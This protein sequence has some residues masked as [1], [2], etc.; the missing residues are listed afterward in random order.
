MIASTFI[1]AL[2]CPK[3]GQFRYIGK[4]NF[5][6]K[7]IRSHI[8]ACSYSS[9]KKN[10]WIKRLRNENMV[11][12]LEILEEVDMERWQFW[13]M[14][15]ISLFKSW[16]F[17]LLNMTDGGE[18]PP[19]N[20]WNLGKKMSEGS[21]RKM[22]LA[23]MG[24]KKRAGNKMP[25]SQKKLLSK[26]NSGNKYSVGRVLS[27]ITKQKI[28]ASNKG[29]HTNIGRVYY[30]KTRQKMSDKRKGIK[31]SYAVRK[32]MSESK[33]GI[34]M[35]DETKIKIGNSNRGKRWLHSDAT[36]AKMKGHK[37]GIG[38]VVSF[39][40]KMKI[41]IANKGRKPAQ[42]SD[43]AKRRISLANTGNRWK[44]S[45]ETKAKM[46]INYVSGTLGK[47]VPVERKLKI[48]ESLKK[49]FISNETKRKDSIYIY[50]N[51]EKRLLLSFLRSIGHETKTTYYRLK[52]KE[53]KD[54]SK[55][56]LKL[57]SDKSTVI[58]MDGTNT[59]CNNDI[60]VVID[61]S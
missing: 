11:P 54:I 28:S 46:R 42:L 40:T 8:S 2:V 55:N 30:E 38:R 45:E 29:K 43:E 27:E 26:I 13:E 3:T 39:E 44:H 60:R 34:K 18:N 6:E 10:S 49:Y 59:L 20:K 50:V 37:R 9:S 56:I 33:K 7:R 15:Y 5:P 57:L 32:K 17:R 53:G 35:S 58:S 19:V 12:V 61:N 14:F 31:L 47:A 41:S 48:S 4:S 25:D 24:N 36:K 1:Y 23:Q 52:L 22:S 21:R 16:G 51:G